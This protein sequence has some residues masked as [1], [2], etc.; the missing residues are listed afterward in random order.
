MWYITT[1]VNFQCISST[2]F[3]QNWCV[4]NLVC[5]HSHQTSNGLWMFIP[6]NLKISTN[7]LKFII[8]FPVQLDQYHIS[9]PNPIPISEVGVVMYHLF[10]QFPKKNPMI[11]RVI[12]FFVGSSLHFW[13]VIPPCSRPIPILFPS[14]PSICVLEIRAAATV[15]DE[16]HGFAA[17]RRANLLADVLLR[18]ARRRLRSGGRG[19]WREL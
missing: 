7:P 19:L 18:L 9:R 5:F 15:E 3:R 4:K 16:A 1:N 2:N 8:I 6:E 10:S 13:V 12:R 17:L 11:L 14:P